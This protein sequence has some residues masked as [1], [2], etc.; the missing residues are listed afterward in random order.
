MRGQN[1]ERACADGVAEGAVDF[2]L[3]G[4]EVDDLAAVLQVLRVAEKH[5]ALDFALHRRR[6]LAYC[7][8]HH[9]RALAIPAQGNGRVG[10]LGRRQVD[11]TLGFRDGR[12]RRAQGQEV[13]GQP[14]GVR[15]ADAL[16]PEG[17]SVPGGEAGRQVG[18]DQGAL[19]GR[20][21]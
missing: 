6:H 5:D 15:T 4:G 20:V 16:H 12:V 19:C 9:C 18:A 14:G 3:V 1:G 11:Q 10:A 7:V 21:G 13:F 2:R 8:A 17:A